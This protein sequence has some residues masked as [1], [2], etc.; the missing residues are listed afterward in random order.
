MT[1]PVAIISVRASSSRLPNK[2]F[3][4]LGNMTV[5]E[6]V[7]RRANY[8]GFRS[9][10]ATSTDRTDDGIYELCQKIGVECFRGSLEDKIDRWFNAFRDYE[11]EF[12]HLIDADDPYF[13]PEECKDSLANLI[14]NK[15]DI[16]FPSLLS[17]GG[18]ASVGTSIAF[19]F[20]SKVFTRT[21][22]LGND[23]DVIPWE[24]I[25]KTG[26][27]ALTLEDDLTVN[28]KT[29]PRLTLDYEEDYKLMQEIAANFAYNAARHEID[30]FLKKNSQLLHLNENRT[31]DFKKNQADFVQNNFGIG[32]I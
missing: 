2:C 9:I 23:F 5:L 6:H 1:Q 4:Q 11:I 12:A 21:R 13:N 22:S 3:L 15:R 28:F 14:E 18:T 8:G 26:D 25:I 29:P 24:A 32:K 7:I 16:I 31:K 20:L 19:S 30:N 10:V 17:N 27:N